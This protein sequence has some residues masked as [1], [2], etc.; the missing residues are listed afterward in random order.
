MT[1]G[2]RA[3]VVTLEAWDV[4]RYRVVKPEA[5]ILYE[6]HHGRGRGHDLG[7]RSEI[8]NRIKGHR[9]F[10]RHGGAEAIR[11]FEQRTITLA[12]HDD[13]AGGVFS[14]H[15]VVNEGVD[16]TKSVDP[17]ASGL[18]AGDNLAQETERQDEKAGE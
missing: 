15:G 5:P 1:N 8:E 14:R 11:L 18:L 16:S 17:S 6:G 3:L 4:R 12:D 13:G 2:N 7:Q 10:R 9:L